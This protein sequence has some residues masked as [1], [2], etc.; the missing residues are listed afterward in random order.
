[1]R[2]VRLCALL[3]VVLLLACRG[4]H[5]PS[6]V[7]IALNWFPEV[8]HGGFFA[9][10]VHGYYKEEGLDVELVSGRPDAPVLPQVAAG[11]AEFGVADASEVLL[12]RAQ[13]VPVVAL[14]AGL[15]H[16]PRCVMV[17][18]DSGVT[19]LADLKDMTLA[20]AAREPFATFLQRRFTWPGVQVVPYTGSVA[21]FLVDPRAAQQAYVFSEPLIAEAEGARVRCLLVAD[22]GFDPYA[23]LLVTSETLLAGRR[24]LAAKI[25]RATVRGW[26]QYLRD[27]SAANAEIRARH[28]E[29]APAIVER[30]A[31]TLN[32]L[33][34]PG[35][36]EVGSM[37]DD[38]W[39][40]LHGQLVD[41]GLVA[42][43][44]VDPD[45]AFTRELLPSPPASGTPAA[46]P[47]TAP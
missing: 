2:L 33:V 16:N 39:R 46:P 9:A 35:G 31:A 28:G 29:L 21:P 13:G 18:A 40:I 37:S 6:R 11:R 20:L 8:E 32:P 12:A 5:D 4:D 44:A 1:M 17:H 30:G 34:D 36:V 22:L 10:L 23:S 19:T 7:R 25:T 41:A 45:A 27:P 47:R 42:A 3:C 43:G 14:A 24:E 26:Q 15:Q 38:R